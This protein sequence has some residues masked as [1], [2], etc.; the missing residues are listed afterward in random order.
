[1]FKLNMTAFSGSI[2]L[3]ATMT[4]SSVALAEEEAKEATPAVVN[5][6]IQEEPTTAGEIV[7]TEASA[8]AEEAQVE[9]SATEGEAK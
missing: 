7:V 8:N 4:L 9:A 6:Q 3:A 2:V 1:M 5:A